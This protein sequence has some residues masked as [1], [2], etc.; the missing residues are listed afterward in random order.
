MS[1]TTYTHLLCHNMIMINLIKLVSLQQE[2]NDV[3]M[4]FRRLKSVQDWFL[5]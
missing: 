4:Q 5:S 3:V 1:I 2:M